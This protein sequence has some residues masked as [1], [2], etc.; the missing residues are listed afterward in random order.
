MQGQSAKGQAEKYTVLHS[1]ASGVKSRDLL[2]IHI[3]PIKLQMNPRNAAYA[4]LPPIALEQLE[5]N[6]AANKTFLK[7]S[8]K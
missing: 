8:A 6:W 2:D 4:P 7:N 1:I 3:L 5:K